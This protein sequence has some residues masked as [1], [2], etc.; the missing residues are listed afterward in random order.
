MFLVEIAVAV[1]ILAES[2][3][4][5][6]RRLRKPEKCV[7][8]IGMICRSFIVARSIYGIHAGHDHV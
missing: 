5:F 2:L 6:R 7:R 3:N 4:G 1:D 8:K